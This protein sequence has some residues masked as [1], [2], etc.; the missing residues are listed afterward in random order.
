[1]TKFYTSV[2]RM[3]SNILYRGYDNG[4]QVKLRIP[5]KPKLYVTGD[6]PI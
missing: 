6:S 5:F 1:M 3:G 4:K 2:L